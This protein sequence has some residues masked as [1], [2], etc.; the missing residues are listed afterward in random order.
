[1]TDIIEALNFVIPVLVLV[2]GIMLIVMPKLPIPKPWS[3]IFGLILIV[4]GAVMI[5]DAS[6]VTDIIPSFPWTSTPATTP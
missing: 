3:I 4:L 2:F 1:M 6:G 5:G